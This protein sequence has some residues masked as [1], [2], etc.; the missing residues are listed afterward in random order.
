MNDQIKTS[1]KDVFMHL[2]AI[3]ALYISVVSFGVLVFQFIDLLFPDQ[4]S[5]FPQGSRDAVRWALAALVVVFPV[6]VWTSWMLAK[7]VSQNP[8]KRELKSRKWLYYFT[9]FAA[10]AII[11]GDIVALIYNFLGGDLSIRFLLKIAAILFIAAAVFCYYLWNI[12]R[13]EMA[14]RDPR[15][16]VFIF[17]VVG[18]VAVSTIAG[19]FVAGSPFRERLRKFDERRVQ[20]LQNIQ[21]QI[22]NYWQRKEKLPATLEELR[23]DISGYIAPSDP[24]SGLVYEYRALASVQFELCAD[25]KTQREETLSV[26]PK[27]VFP[28]GRG[29]SESWTHG[30]G[31]VCFSRTIDSEL[32]PVTKF[33]IR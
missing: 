31:R 15:M 19:F 28:E 25:F 8:E 20:D 7:D 12:R 14:S 3:I 6:Y 16:R 17:A 33:P 22:V 2:L 23:D 30:I 32:Y 4:L 21:W 9:L 5:Y 24:E 1:P 13:E 27:Q 10:S 29:I 26:A 18:I 11:I